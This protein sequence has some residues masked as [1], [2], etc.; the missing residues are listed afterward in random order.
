VLATPHGN[1]SIAAADSAS[2]R[3]AATDSS[4]QIWQ[5]QPPATATSVPTPSPTPPTIYVVRAGDSY[6]VIA[7]NFNISMDQLLQANHLTVESI[8]HPGD[9]LIIP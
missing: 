5:T 4:A 7:R 2:A 9:Q 3:H 6:S 8:P 1:D